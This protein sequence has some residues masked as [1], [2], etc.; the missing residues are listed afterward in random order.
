MSHQRRSLQ[1]A[2]HLSP[3]PCAGKYPAAEWKAR[4]DL[5]ATYRIAHHLNWDQHIYNHITLRV[6]G[7]ENEPGGPFFLINPFGLRFDE[8]TA[9]NLLKVDLE[10]NVMDPGTGVASH[11]LRTDQDYAQV[12]GRCSS[13]AL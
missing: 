2:R 5:A 9:S 3:E 10:G 11:R 12:P 6:D 4:C 8:V 13:R 7:S 1:L